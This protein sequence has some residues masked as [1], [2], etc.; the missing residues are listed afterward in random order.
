MA[1]TETIIAE[2]IDLYDSAVARLRDDI[3]IYANTGTPP[4]LSR[5]SDGSYSYPELRIRLDDDPRT[6]SNGRAF[7]RLAQRGN[8]A[9]TITR[10]A[11]FA[12]YLT[13]QIELIGTSYN[14][15]IEVGRSRQEIPFP[16]VLDGAYGAQIALVSPQELAK[17]F[18][19][20]DLAHIGDEIADGEFN[21][22][23]GPFPLSLFDG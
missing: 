11:L 7:G 2:L 23:D 4:P 8:Y 9:C 20:T 19:A 3:A 15:R 14:V 17:H 18:P 16:Y 5:R 6:E 22:G 1:T 21:V 10:P 13:E 12:D